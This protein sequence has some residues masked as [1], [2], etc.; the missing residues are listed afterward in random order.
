MGLDDIIERRFSG[1]AV[2]RAIGMGGP[3]VGDDDCKPG[4]ERRDPG[5]GF[6]QRFT[7]KF[8]WL[9]FPSVFLAYLGQTAA[10]VSRHSSGGAAVAGYVIIVVFCLAYLG[11]LQYS[12]DQF[13]D[14]A[15]KPWWFLFALTAIAGVES[16]FAHE[17]AFVML[18]YVV[19]LAISRMGARAL[20]V[21]VVAV[22]AST[23]VPPLVP[24][25]HAEAD[26]GLGFSML[27]VA[28]AMWAFFGVIRVNRQL[29]QA[30]AEV[31]QLAAEGER[32][33]IARDLHDLLGHSLTTITVKAGLA[34]R[35]A[36]QDPERAAVEIGEV[37]ELARQ[38]LADVRAA[39]SGYREVTIGGELASG[40]ELLRAA[41]I[42]ARFPGAVDA[43]LPANQE[44]F[45][46]V[47]R[48]GITNVVR[49][50]RATTCDVR[51]GPNWVEVRDDGP[52]GF[53]RDTG[54]GLTGLRERVAEVGGTVE[55]GPSASGTGW[56]LRVDV[57]EVAAVDPAPVS[58]PVRDPA[59]D[60]ADDPANQVSS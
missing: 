22:T 27:I 58:V 38:S 36:A 37:E 50:A 15:W 20:P 28:F 14:E 26:W 39:V 56:L 41:D 7:T 17:D 43:V 30:R 53:G 60:P 55:S 2:P 24:A 45:G 6:D 29:G 47:V 34:K 11:S 32:N 12:R 5:W 23:F 25:W 21:V 49:H 54:K 1:N 13:L 19:V 48:E 44:L 10:G 8:R 42:D 4:D 51:L 18:I 57:P 31:A 16:I 9:I 59:G 52:G 40:R 3:G 46:W 35:L 33:R